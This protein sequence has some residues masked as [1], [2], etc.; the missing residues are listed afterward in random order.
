MLLGVIPVHIV[1]GVMGGGE[2]DERTRDLAYRIGALIAREGW[3]LLNGGRDEGVME[4]S[5][6]GARDAGGLT[7]GVLP[8]R[9]TSRA[10]EYIDVPIVTD[11]GHGGTTSTYSPPKW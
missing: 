3:V 9:D 6:K 1:I 8:D 11:M 5:A 4:A 7:V 2:A 10:S